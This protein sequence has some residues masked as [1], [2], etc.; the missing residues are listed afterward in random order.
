MFMP[1]PGEF[2]GRTGGQHALF[3]SGDALERSLYGGFSSL[4]NRNAQNL[5]N[6][7]QGSKKLSPV[8]RMT[9]R[10]HSFCTEYFFCQIRGSFNYCAATYLY[11]RDACK[12]LARAVTLLSKM[13]E[14]ENGKT[15][16]NLSESCNTTLKDEEKRKWKTLCKS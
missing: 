9:K 5:L 7:A 11:L 6:M 2:G 8:G 14:R 13:R 1:A 4:G 10:V 12:I 3:C 16:V 15:C